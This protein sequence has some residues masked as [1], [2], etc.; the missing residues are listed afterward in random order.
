[1]GGVCFSTRFLSSGVAKEEKGG[2][3]SFLGSSLAGQRHMLL[4]EILAKLSF[5]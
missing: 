4:L 1:M 3:L 2:Q 5:A